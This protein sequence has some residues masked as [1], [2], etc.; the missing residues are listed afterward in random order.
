MEIRS[1]VTVG[2]G[3]IPHIEHSFFWFTD[4]KIT[5]DYADGVRIRRLMWGDE[6]QSFAQAPQGRLR[7]E[8]GVNDH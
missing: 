7:L 2:E 5:H 1:R 4:I 3:L 6:T 8:V